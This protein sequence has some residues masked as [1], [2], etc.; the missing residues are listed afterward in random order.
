[1]ESS[2]GASRPGGGIHTRIATHVDKVLVIVLQGMLRQG[3]AGDATSCYQVVKA[4]GELAISEDGIHD[5]TIASSLSYM[6][7]MLQ[8]WS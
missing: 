4:P 1:M 7:L 8:D 6:R 3:D 2:S 5:R